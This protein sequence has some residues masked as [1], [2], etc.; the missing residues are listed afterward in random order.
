MIQVFRVHTAA[1]APSVELIVPGMARDAV[2]FDGTPW[3][4]LTRER[5][6]SGRVVS[7]RGGSKQF[8][9]VDLGA[10]AIPEAAWSE[11]EKMYYCCSMGS[12]LLAVET[13]LGDFRVIHPLDVLPKPDVS[14]AP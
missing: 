7:L 6:F 5:A 14:D 10:F 8:Y 2:C 13:P 9:S 11:C 4:Q 12:E 1:T 3:A